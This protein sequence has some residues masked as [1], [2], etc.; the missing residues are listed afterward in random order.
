MPFW[1]PPSHANNHVSTLLSAQVQDHAS[2]RQPSNH[3]PVGPRCLLIAAIALIHLIH[4]VKRAP[5]LVERIPG[6]DGLAG[7][8]GRGV[9]GSGRLLGRVVL[10]GAGLM[11]GGGVGGRER[12]ALETGGESVTA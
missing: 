9:P 2:L 10:C 11:L 3:P 8:S 6:V 1:F 4:L 12:A 5:R 7:G